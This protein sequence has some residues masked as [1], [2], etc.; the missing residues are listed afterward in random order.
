MIERRVAEPIIPLRLFGI[1][2]FSLATA[3][4][5]LAGFAM[6]GGITFLPQYQQFVQGASATN[7]G[8][9]LMPMMIAAMVVS[10]GGGQVISQHRP[11][12]DVPDRRHGPARRRPVAVLHD[13]RRHPDLGDQRSTW[14]SSAPAWAA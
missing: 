7:S 14:W 4:G 5:F 3:L 8:L 10:L 11:L 9:L 13:G 12:P 6:F 2:N 1:A